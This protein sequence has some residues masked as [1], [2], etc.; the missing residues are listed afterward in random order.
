MVPPSA[1]HFKVFGFFH[2]QNGDLC[3][4][5]EATVRKAIHQVCSAFSELKDH[6]IKSPD[7][8]GKTNYK[9]E[10]HE[11]GNCPEAMAVKTL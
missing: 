5:S 10:F 4:A 2:C 6:Y 11:Y 1:D 7:A 3:D 9:L 8:A